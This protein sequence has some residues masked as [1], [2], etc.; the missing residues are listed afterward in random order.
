MSS[1]RAVTVTHFSEQPHSSPEC[2]LHSVS[3]PHRPSLGLLL[4]HPEFFLCDG[5]S[6]PATMGWFKSAPLCPCLK[7]HYHGGRDK[8]ATMSKP[9]M[10]NAKILSQDTC[11]RTRS[12]GMTRSIRSLLELR[13]S[14]T[15]CISHI[16]LHR[17]NYGKDDE[18]IARHTA[19]MTQQPANHLLKDPSESNLE[20]A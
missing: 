6:E 5:V 9:V 8:T 11:M 14:H 4:T 7:T 20:L 12:A 17:E 1:A 15:G 19:D 10:E 16:Q 3:P 13:G 2:A 18:N